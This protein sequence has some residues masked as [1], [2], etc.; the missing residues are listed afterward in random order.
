MNGL[1]WFL[2]ISSCFPSLKYMA[3][4]LVHIFFFLIFQEIFPQQNAASFVI[5]K[6]AFLLSLFGRLPSLFLASNG[7]LRFNTNKLRIRWHNRTGLIIFA[8]RRTRYSSTLPA[9]P[10]ARANEAPASPS[11]PCLWRMP[12]FFPWNFHWAQ[13]I[14]WVT[15]FYEMSHK[16][17]ALPHKG[18]K[19]GPLT[20]KQGL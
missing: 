5:F 14:S 16:C 11:L 12:F 8:A 19:N 17:S 3:V 10:I 4:W 7:Q 15:M 13:E 2:L 18:M 9:L 6:A 1:S 20:W